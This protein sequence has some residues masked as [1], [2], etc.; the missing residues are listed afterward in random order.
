M[1]PSRPV[2]VE[3]C[4]CSLEGEQELDTHGSCVLLKVALPIVSDKRSVQFVYTVKQ[5]KSRQNAESQ[6]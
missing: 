4:E 1:R 6:E 3:L 5:M 2:A